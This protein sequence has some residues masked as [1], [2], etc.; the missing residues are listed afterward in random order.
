MS[1]GLK[2]LLDK[3]ILHRDLKPQNILLTNEYNIKITDFGFARKI[4][5]DVL[6]NTLCGSPM[7]MAPEIINKQDYNYKSDLWSVGVILYQMF[8]GT[9]PFNVNNFVQL[10]KKINSQTIDYDINN[11]KISA[12]G[13]QLLK[14]LLE[15][16][17]E[18]ELL[19]KIFFIILG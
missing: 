15:I 6:L 5:K 17:V 18:K 16:N 2:Y 7:Y 10:I 12:Q 4:N 13:L 1:D 11:I 3:D 9:V 19:G 8:Y 14:S